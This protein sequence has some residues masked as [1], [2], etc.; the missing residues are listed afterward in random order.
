MVWFEACQQAADCHDGWRSQQPTGT[1]VVAK[2][3]KPAGF[4]RSATKDRGTRWQPLG[5]PM[6]YS[7]HTLREVVT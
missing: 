5:E 1:V 3:S 4:D 2:A 7:S 6:Q